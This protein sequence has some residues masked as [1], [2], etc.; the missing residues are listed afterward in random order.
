MNASILSS[1]LL[2]IDSLGGLVVGVFVVGTHRWLADWYGLPEGLLLFTG[3]A[4]LAYGAFSRSLARRSER[5]LSLIKVLASANILWTFV[6]AALLARYGADAGI[7]GVLHLGAE[8]LYVGALGALEW[9]WRESLRH[10]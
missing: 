2:W 9:R 3:I 6:C 1:R 4:N 5:P 8:G 7:L 10:S